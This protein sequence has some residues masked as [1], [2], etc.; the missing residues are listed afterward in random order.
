MPSP[1]AIGTVVALGLA[2]WWLRGGDAAPKA[3]PL[4]ATPREAP[5][6]QPVVAPAI[7]P[8]VTI[9]R[10]PPTLAIPLAPAKRDE[11]SGIVRDRATGEPLAGTTVIATTAT[12]E[13]VA[14]ADEDGRYTL[15]GLAPGT[16]TL[17]LYYLGISA[18]PATADGDLDLD[19][20]PVPTR[21]F[22]SVLGAAAGTQG[23]GARF[24]SDCGL[25]N[26]YILE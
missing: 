4:P 6:S 17:T 15:A 18:T 16:Y 10:R 19:L 12:G 20:I 8:T 21:T 24:A 5:T 11:V 14:I 23:D 25:E 22:E 2:A 26:T 13:V 1:S 7:A 9:D 3:A